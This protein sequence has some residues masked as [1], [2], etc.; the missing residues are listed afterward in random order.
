MPNLEA[1]IRNR[2]TLYR[3]RIASNLATLIVRNPV[4]KGMFPLATRS[5]VLTNHRLAHQT[6]SLA[7]RKSSLGLVLALLVRMTIS[8]ERAA[9]LMMNF[10][11]TKPM[12]AHTMGEMTWTS[13]RTTMA[14]LIVK[15]IP[16]RVV[17]VVAAAA[18]ESIAMM[19]TSKMK[20]E[21]SMLAQAVHLEM[22]TPMSN[23]QTMALLFG[24]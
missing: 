13:F 10:K 2:A 4:L 11:G 14:L 16:D 22:M 9:P 1:A 21:T 15:R 3:L 17:G 12:L 7:Q 20:I 24:K 8:A 18:E 5:N 23:L 6:K 19:R